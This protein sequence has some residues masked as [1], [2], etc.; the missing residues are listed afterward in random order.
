MVEDEGPFAPDYPNVILMPLSDDGR[1]V[2]AS[3]AVEIVPTVEK[4]CIKAC[5]AAAHLVA[6]TSKKQVVSTRS[7]VTGEELRAIRRVVGLAVGME[8]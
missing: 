1:L 4:G 3:L 8:G 7:R 2:T 6:A 5:W